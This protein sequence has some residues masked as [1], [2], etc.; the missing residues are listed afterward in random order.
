[1]IGTSFAPSTTDQF[2]ESCATMACMVRAKHSD[3]NREMHQNRLLGASG[4][5]QLPRSQERMPS[6][7]GFIFIPF[8][9]GRAASLEQQQAQQGI[10]QMA[11]ENAQAMLRPSLPERDLL[12][13]WN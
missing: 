7:R 10:Y 6:P 9:W 8:T 4:V 12:G 13:V 1:M 11:W 5:Y 2:L 3:R